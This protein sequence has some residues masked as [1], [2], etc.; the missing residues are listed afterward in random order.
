MNL[1]METYLMTVHHFWCFADKNNS[2]IELSIIDN[3]ELHICPSFHVS[4][5]WQDY[6]TDILK[7]I[8]SCSSGT[9]SVTWALIG[10]QPVSSPPEQWSSGRHP[11]SCSSPRRTPTDVCRLRC[12]PLAP[13][14][15]A[16]RA[17]GSLTCSSG[18][19]WEQRE[20]T[21][22]SKKALINKLI[23]HVRSNYL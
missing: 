9:K 16:T 11:P 17:A 5:A 19:Q 14:Y 13:P 22:W 8:V 6:L 2:P 21:G 10:R 23:F 3:R 4:T 12:S 15:R 7:I 18:L 20:M 1:K